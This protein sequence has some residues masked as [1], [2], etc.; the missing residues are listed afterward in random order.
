MVTGGWMMGIIC[1]ISQMSETFGRRE[2]KTSVCIHLYLWST[3]C[4]K[5]PEI[6]QIKGVCFTRKGPSHPSRLLTVDQIASDCM[7]PTTYWYKVEGREDYFKGCQIW[8][9][10]NLSQPRCS[11]THSLEMITGIPMVKGRNSPL[12][13]T[14]ASDHQSD[15]WLLGL[16]LIIIDSLSWFLSMRFM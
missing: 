11:R 8:I 15:V 4:I 2:R 10:I 3:C 13:E 16:L 14:S 1:I 9:V 12:T 5:F 7:L 6:P